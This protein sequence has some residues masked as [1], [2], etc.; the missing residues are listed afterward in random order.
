MSVTE[1]PTQKI[2]QKPAPETVV[3]GEPK[4]P[5]LKDSENLKFQLGLW[6][7]GL[8]SFLKLYS[9]TLARENYLSHDWSKE[10]RITHSVLLLC[11][12]LSLEYAHHLKHEGDS[13]GGAGKH[14]G[15][16]E[17]EMKT[18]NLSY[19]EVFGLASALKESVLLSEVLLK[20]DSLK[21]SDWTAWNDS[22]FDKLK[23][24]VAVQKLINAAE[25]VGGKYLPERLLDLMNQHDIPTAM[26]ADLKV[27]LPYFGKVL[28]WL[29][30]IGEL[31][32][33][34]KPLKSSLLL[35][36]HI[37]EQM[38]EMMTYIN[39]R[40]SRYPNE[41]DA[42]FGSLDSA[43]YTASIELRKV[44]NRELKELTEVRPTT[45][46]QAK[47]ENSYALLNDSLQLT[48]VNFAQ[49][50]DPETDSN[51]L[52]ANLKTKE[53]QSLILREEMWKVLQAVQA[54]EAT[55]EQK[56]VDALYAQLNDFSENTLRYLFYKDIETV[57]RFIEEVLRTKDQKD[58]VPILHRFG[59]YLETLVGQINNRIVLVNHPFE[60]LQ[61]NP[62]DMFG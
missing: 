37:N 62:L 55:P 54:A 8:E 52:F 59:A 11:S 12:R 4:E 18:P 33:H 48:L 16:I 23:N 6:L 47:I 21:F 19:R 60:P 5:G 22:L 56:S 30:V 10:F 61:Q 3:A 58:L 17:D 29:S 26:D 2:E 28:K 41:A 40:L 38:H 46:V 24:L 36:A 31:L 14:V 45:L 15:T 53:E 34:D 7:S 49:L 25:D 9:N 1:T 32:E 20:A 51:S 50:I 27:V 43:A 39:N 35:F 44:Y 13:K 42:L 57:E